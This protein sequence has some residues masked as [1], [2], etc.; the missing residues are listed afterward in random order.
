MYGYGFHPGQGKS[1]GKGGWFEKGKGKGKD[2][3][4]GKGK[5]NYQNRR[6]QVT[7]KI[8]TSYYFD[9]Y[10]DAAKGKRWIKCA[11]S[12]CFGCILEESTVKNCKFCES[13][14]KKS[15]TRARSN[16]PGNSSAGHAARADND[17]AN[18]AQAYKKLLERGFPEKEAIGL[19]AQAGVN[20][21]PPKEKQVN[22]IIN[23]QEEIDKTN[24]EIRTQENLLRQQ[25]DRH[26]KL[27]AQL[28]EAESKIDVYENH[29]KEKKMKITE[30]QNKCAQEIGPKSIMLQTAAAMPH[31]QEADLET[32]QQMNDLISANFQNAEDANFVM[33]GFMNMLSQTYAHVSTIS[34]RVDDLEKDKVEL[35]SENVALKTQLAQ[36]W[37]L[38]KQPASRE[39]A[40]VSTTTGSI[41]PSSKAKAS[42]PSPTPANSHEQ[43]V[44]RRILTRHNTGDKGSDAEKNQLENYPPD[45]LPRQ[46]DGERAN[47]FG[48]SLGLDEDVDV[49]KKPGAVLG[50]EA[51]LSEAEQCRSKRQRPST[52][53]IAKQ[54]ESRQ[55]HNTFAALASAHDGSD[56][57]KDI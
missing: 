39:V 47:P 26:D 38:P 21:K 10:P 37:P 17:E 15:T 53:R 46:D 45:M 6:G 30:L 29:I 18:P 35:Q 31:S 44:A 28:D 33:S 54:N 20:F 57:E 19:L 52:V 13:E 40:V 2:N 14:F 8:P 56:E 16:S 41:K 5:G 48:L 25:K 32:V 7:A 23:A 51:K 12:G 24:A 1:K 55:T 36:V 27:M 11:K 3:F 42:P 4:K 9:D 50:S 34:S 22:E 49:T 43:E